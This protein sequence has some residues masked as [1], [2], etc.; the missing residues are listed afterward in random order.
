MRYHSFPVVFSDKLT[1]LT[2]GHFEYKYFA[3]WLE[4][5]IDNC[6]CSN[7]TSLTVDAYASGM[8]FSKTRSD[9]QETIHLM[10]KF[11]NKF[12]KLEKL[13]FLL[14]AGDKAST[15]L[16]SVFTK[17]LKPILLKNNTSVSSTQKLM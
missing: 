8:L 9:D 14:K 4:F 17:A 2:I 11:A 1:S 15:Y 5:T 10:T 13:K 3:P 16:W 12:V 7:I 6:D